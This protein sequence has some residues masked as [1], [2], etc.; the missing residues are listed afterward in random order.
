MFHGT[1]TLVSL[2]PSRTP[3]AT[4]KKKKK[5]LRAAPYVTRAFPFEDPSYKI[6]VH[7]RRRRAASVL[8]P[9]CLI[10]RS[11]RTLY[12]HTCTIFVEL[13]RGSDLRRQRQIIGW[14]FSKYRS[15]GRASAHEHTS[16]AE[17]GGRGRDRGMNLP[18]TVRINACCWPTERS[19]LSHGSAASAAV[20]CRVYHVWN[21]TSSAYLQQYSQQQSL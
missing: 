19:R 20:C 1:Q 15:D 6:D 7:A 13:V 2:S 9:T 11:H 17:G 21:M 16:W 4:T 10:V 5:G 18:Q 3:R 12:V 14:L 8:S